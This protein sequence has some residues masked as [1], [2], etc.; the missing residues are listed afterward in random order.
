MEAELLKMILTYLGSDY[1]EDQE[2]IL[3]LLIQKAIYGF[4][5]FM[6]YPEYFTEE[7]IQEDLDK[8][9]FCI[10]ELALYSY[11]MQGVEFQNSHSENGT[12]RSWNSETEI[13]NYYGLVP[14]VN[15]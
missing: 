6:N 13:Y 8:N 15:L 1:S 14:Y 11:N 7:K 2:P 3:L 4:K 5:S 10:F 12:S 9:K